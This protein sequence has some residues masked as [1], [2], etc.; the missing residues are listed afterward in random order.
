MVSIPPIVAQGYD[1]ADVMSGSENE[2]QSK[3]RKDHPLAVYIHRMAH[4]L[5]W[6]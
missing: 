2:V 5:I 4:K 3:I 1:G 6:F